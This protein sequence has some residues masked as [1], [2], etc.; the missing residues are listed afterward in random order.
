M[1]YAAIDAG[2]SSDMAMAIRQKVSELTKPI[3]DEPHESERSEP[4]LGRILRDNVHYSEWLFTDPHR[5][6]KRYVDACNRNMIPPH[7]TL[8]G[9]GLSGSIAA[10]ILATATHRMY[11]VVRKS[12]VS[13]HSCN[14]VE[15]QIGARW[16]F[17]D[18]FVRSGRTRER[19]IEKIVDEVPRTRFVGSWLYVNSTFHDHTRIGGL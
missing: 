6:I 1:K 2:V 10:G 16:L 12:G 11:A 7:D 18:D 4:E 3:T 15:G 19:V 13:T 8:I 14:T 9:T 17:I 5:V